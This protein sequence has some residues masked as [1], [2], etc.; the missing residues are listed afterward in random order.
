MKTL[1]NFRAVN[2]DL[3]VWT[4]ACSQHVYAFFDS[5]YDVPEQRIPAKTGMTVREAV[6]AFV[7][8]DQKVVLIDEAGWP[9]NS[10]CAY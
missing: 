1:S 9:A 5:F 7:L 3:S 4:I 8:Y 2:P 6:E 10:G